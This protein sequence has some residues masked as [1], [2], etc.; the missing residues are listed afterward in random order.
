MFTLIAVVTHLSQ[1]I[2]TTSVGI[3]QLSGARR[4]TWIGSVSPSDGDKQIVID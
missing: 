1:T 2:N 3:K 4:D